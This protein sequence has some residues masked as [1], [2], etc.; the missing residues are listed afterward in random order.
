MDGQILVF[1]RTSLAPSTLPN[2][3]SDVMKHSEIDDLHFFLTT[4]PNA[5]QL[6]AEITGARHIAQKPRWGL[7]PFLKQQ[8]LLCP[9]DCQA[10]MLI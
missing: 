8:W 9:A 7:G 2:T 6:N 1:V 3:R 5:G 10:E 4:L